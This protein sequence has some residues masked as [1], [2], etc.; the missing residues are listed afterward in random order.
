VRSISKCPKCGGLDGYGQFKNVVKGAGWYLRAQEV[1]VLFC[2]NCDIEMIDSAPFET[3]QVQEVNFVTS[4]VSLGGI[5]TVLFL[6]V[7][8]VIAYL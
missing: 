2:R 4:R 1:Q 8:F 6:L 5:V 7:I 3:G